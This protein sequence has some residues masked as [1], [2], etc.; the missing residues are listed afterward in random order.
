MDRLQYGST[1]PATTPPRHIRPPPPGFAVNEKLAFKELDTSLTTKRPTCDGDDSDDSDDTVQYNPPSQVNGAVNTEAPFESIN[2]PSLAT[3]MRLQLPKTDLLHISVQY[4]RPPS[5][6]NVQ[7][8]GKNHNATMLLHVLLPGTVVNGVLV[9]KQPGNTWIVYDVYPKGSHKFGTK[10]PSLPHRY[11]WTKPDDWSPPV[12]GNV[13]EKS[14]ESSQ[15]DKAKALKEESKEG[16]FPL[17]PKNPW[18]HEIEIPVGRKEIPSATESE[19]ELIQ[20]K[21]RG[22]ELKSQ[23]PRYQARRYNHNAFSKRANRANAF[24]PMLSR[25]KGEAIQRRLDPESKRLSAA[26]VRDHPTVAPSDNENATS[27]M[28]LTEPS[29]HGNSSSTE[30]HIPAHAPVAPEDLSLPLGTLGAVA[31][32]R[33]EVLAHVAE[34]E[35]RLEKKIDTAKQDDGRI[36]ELEV[37][38]KV[39]EE[40]KGEYKKKIVGLQDDIKELKRKE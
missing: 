31:N 19:K 18:D 27:A 17:P 39:S 21:A 14:Q 1:R 26:K 10:K 12:V 40:E 3:A 13:A 9:S 11:S 35:A 4:D 7:S 22:E 29:A 20:Q 37:R 32:L 36:L 28:E 24:Q 16:C 30:T 15:A 8:Q 5:N 6:G 25:D 34:L 38:L 33:Q 2:Q 23:L